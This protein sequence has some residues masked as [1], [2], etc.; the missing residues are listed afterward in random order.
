MEVMGAV[1][2]TWGYR[3][4]A[5][6]RHNHISGDSWETTEKKFLYHSV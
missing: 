6:A 2:T 1:R 5:I 4:K 3:S